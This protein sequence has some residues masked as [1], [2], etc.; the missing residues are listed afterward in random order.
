[1]Y[2]VV[3]EIVDT[4]VGLRVSPWPVVDNRG[5]LRFP[6]SGRR[7]EVGV[8]LGKLHSFIRKHRRVGGRRPGSYPEELRRRPVRIGDVFAVRCKPNTSWPV[9]DDLAP[10]EWIQ[11]PVWDLSADAREQAKT[12]FYAAVAPTL[13][14]KESM[15]LGLRATRMAGPR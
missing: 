9:G 8:S 6:R 14:P 4:A 5:R 15:R 12:A 7:A 3:D 13:R 11:P 1:M 2:V 10:Q